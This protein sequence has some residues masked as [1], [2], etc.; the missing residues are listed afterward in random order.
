MWAVGWSRS[1]TRP[2][3]TLAHRLGHAQRLEVLAGQLVAQLI[4]VLDLDDIKAATGLERIWELR[5]R[6]WR[7]NDLM[8][9]GV[10]GRVRA[11]RMGSQWPTDARTYAASAWS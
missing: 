4:E 7:M 2:E 9:R 3:A 5:S 1:L 10:T 11:A 8:M 6:R